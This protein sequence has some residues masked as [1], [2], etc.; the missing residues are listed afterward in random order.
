M[1]TQSVMA[2]EADANLRLLT[3]TG[4]GSVAVETSVAVVRLGVVIEG[5][6]AQETHQQVAQRSNQL[7]QKLKA[8]Q[9]EN[10]QTTGISLNPRYDYRDGQ[11]KPMG[12]IG[13]NSVQCE[14]PIDQAGQILDQ[15]IAAGATQIESVSFKAS[16]SVM[17]EGRKLALQAAVQDAQ[18]QATDVL[19]SLN[20]SIQSIH[21]IQVDANDSSPIIMRLEA[22]KAYNSM[23]ADAPTPVEGGEQTVTARVTLQIRY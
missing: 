21:S 10:L 5:Q 3:V 18:R 15:A 19:S 8:L 13:Q 4:Q 11:A 22:A 23:M 6:S 9:V 20:F 12:V 16:D 2:A 7:V 14:V 17:K 1:L